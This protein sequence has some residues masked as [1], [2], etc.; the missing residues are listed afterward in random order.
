[1]KQI[2]EPATSSSYKDQIKVHN[3]NI[4]ILSESYF[5][6]MNELDEIKNEI[7]RQN[8]LISDIK[9]EMKGRRWIGLRRF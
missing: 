1:M 7:N 5:I 4:S 3:R 2:Y 8:E 6:K 9:F